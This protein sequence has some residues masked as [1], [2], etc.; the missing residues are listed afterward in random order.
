M[1]VSKVT[2]NGTIQMDVTDTTVAS[3]TQISGFTALNAAGN[4]ITGTVQIPTK[5]S[6]LTNDSGFITS[7]GAPVQSVNGQTGIVVIS[8]PTATSDL[9]NDSDYVS[10]ASYV[11]TDNN[12][13][14]AEKNKL[15]EIASGAEV[16][17]NA[18]SNVKVDSTTIAADT[19]TDTLTLTAGS[20]VTITPNATTDAITIAATDTKYTASTGSVGSASGW[21]AGSTPTLGTAISADDITSWSAGTVTTVTAANGR[22]SVTTGTPSAQAYTARTIPN[23]T[24]VGTLP[25]LTVTDTSVVTDITAS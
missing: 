5:T 22:V 3:D 4:N 23:V 11:H 16:N 18:F 8:I 25:E 2:L 13:T 12:F 14:T 19:T 10:D 6:D 9:T 21:S 24:N 17:Q 20:N 1:G 7:A 15:S